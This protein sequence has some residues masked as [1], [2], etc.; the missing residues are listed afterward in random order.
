VNGDS[1]WVPAGLILVVGGG[2]GGVK[3]YAAYRNGTLPT[4][5]VALIVA[6][7]VVLLLAVVVVVVLRLRHASLPPLGS[8]PGSSRPTSAARRHGCCPGSTSRT[9]TTWG[10]LWGG[11]CGGGWCCARTG[12]PL[13]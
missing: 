2:L 1:P 12:S 10:C 4:G 9:R 5:L 6:A 13:A 8:C 3:L 11:R 7:V